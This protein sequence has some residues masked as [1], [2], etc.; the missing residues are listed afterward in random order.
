MKRQSKHT[1]PPHISLYLRSLTWTPAIGNGSYIWS[2]Q[3]N[4]PCLDQSKGAT[5]KGKKKLLKEMGCH[6][7]DILFPCGIP[8]LVQTWFPR[9]PIPNYNPSW[10]FSKKI[11]YLLLYLNNILM[12]WC[13]LELS[14]HIL[15]IISVGLLL[16]I[17][18]FIVILK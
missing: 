11:Q 7:L 17:I 15:T 6:W 4:F 3:G 9:I 8:L 2:K 1:K 10:V 5:W 13:K 12:E 14:F 18:F 16:I